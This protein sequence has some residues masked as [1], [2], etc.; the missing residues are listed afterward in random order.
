MPQPGAQASTPAATLKFQIPPSDLQTALLRFSA[1]AHL[2]V[3]SAANAVGGWKTSGVDGQYTIGQALQRL[4]AT[5]NLDFRLKPGVVTVG[6]FT[7]QAQQAASPS[8]AGGGDAPDPPLLAQADTAAPGAATPTTPAPDQLQEVIVTAE[9]RAQNVQTIPA[10]VETVDSAALLQSGTRN[11]YDLEKVS[12]AI[13][14]TNTGGTPLLQIRGIQASLTTVSVQAPNAVYLNGAF[15]PEADSI[16]GQFFDV[17]RMEVL[18]GPQ[19]TLYGD[20][21]VGGAIN[22]ITNQPGPQYGAT[23]TLEVGNFNLLHTDAAADLPISDTL[24][25]RLAVHH[26]SH[27]GYLA[28]GL[29]DAGENAARATF[30]WKPDA[31]QQLQLTLD[32]EAVNFRGDETNEALVSG[33]DPSIPIT[34]Q[35]NNN[36]VYGA[37]PPS[38]YRSSDLGQT[39]QYDRYFSAATFTVLATNRQFVQHADQVGAVSVASPG[40]TLS[41]NSTR[42][43]HNFSQQ[44]LEIRVA[45]SGNRSLQYVAGLYAR[46]NGD[47]GGLGIYGAESGAFNT[48]FGAPGG[49]LIQYYNRDVTRG[50]AL[51]GQTVWTPTQLSQFHL[52]TGVR[53][54]YDHTTDRNYTIGLIAPVVPLNTLSADWKAFTWRGELA[55]DVAPQ[56]MVYAGASKGFEPGGFAWAPP[57]VGTPQ[58]KPEYAVSY[59]GGVKSELFDRRLQAN[60]NIYRTFYTDQQDVFTF[61]VFTPAGAAVNGGITNFKS[62]TYQGA[63]LDLTALFTPRDQLAIKAQYQEGISGG[64][65]LR[66]INVQL[67]DLPP[68]QRFASIPPW[69]VNT[70]YMHDF[71]I[72]GGTLSP[73]VVLNYWHYLPTTY[74]YA[75]TSPVDANQSVVIPN[76]NVARWDFNLMFQ[77]AN[78][79]WNVTAYVHNVRNTYDA[80]FSGSTNP[81]SGPRNYNPAAVTNPAYVTI[82][83]MPPRT[84]GLIWNLQF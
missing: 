17:Q 59:E 28:N 39:L 24:L 53:G 14:V 38:F 2:Q 1:Q 75:A 43:V 61:L 82:S 4:L 48:S 45:S 25:S 55:Y 47:N 67:A 18:E 69:S 65:N 12:P 49:P 6:H 33:G 68:G 9:R 72:G 36:N 83:P 78:A 84:Y 60:V 58:Y 42:N 56:I 79:K 80:T 22:I 63:S 21:A 81:S 20:N 23:A 46:A 19:G 29:N 5:T 74:T 27:E 73:Q 50:Y 37:D 32:D 76:P 64:I 57:G 31:S 15:L 62:V 34:P 35:W 54:S 11:V 52:T 66:S 70:S 44:T 16:N 51:F 26:Y 30:L 8:P 7:V 40:N 10:Q 77:P 3:V 41:T 71:N 13:Q